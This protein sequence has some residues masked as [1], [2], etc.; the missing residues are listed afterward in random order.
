MSKS[1][2]PECVAFVRV[3]KNF[4]LVVLAIVA[5]SVVPVVIEI[6]NARREAAAG[7]HRLYRID[8][9][10]IVMQAYP[11]GHM[12]PLTQPVSHVH[13]QFRRCVPHTV[14]GMMMSQCTQRPHSMLCSCDCAWEWQG[15]RVPDSYH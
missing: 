15:G 9:I 4:T 2:C 5:V 11:A 7:V 12:G 13:S 3:Q 6:L 1:E 8:S 14:H 10:G